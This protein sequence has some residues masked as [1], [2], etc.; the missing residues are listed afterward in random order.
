VQVEKIKDMLLSDMEVLKAPKGYLKAG[1]PYFDTLFGRDSL[2]AAWQML[3]ID[4]RIAKATLYWLAFYQAETINDK[5]DRE[6][7]RI[8]HVLRNNLSD[9][10]NREYA[11][12]G[13][14]DSTPLFIIVAGEYFKVTLDKDFLLQIWSNIVAAVNWMAVYGDADDDHLVEYERK[15][16]YGDFHQGWKD[17]VEDHLQI[18][19]PVAIVEVQGYAYAAYRAAADLAV[20]LGKDELF[21]NSWFEKAE[22]LRRTFHRSF[23]WE[24]ESYYYLALDGSKK[25]RESITSNP[26]HLLFTGIVPEEVLEKVIERIFQPDLFTPYG[27]RTVSENDPAFDPFSYH[28]GSV[29]PHD[30][31]IVYNG[32]KKLGFEK[33]ANRIKQALLLAYQELE[34]MPE[35]FR[36]EGGRI[37]PLTE[38]PEYVHHPG[39]NLG[40]ANRLQAW[41]ICALLDMLQED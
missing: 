16:Q 24:E 7:G 2:I 29:W 23:W 1:N 12:F 41:A 34:C 26:G 38:G 40:Y 25:P 9:M 6:P 22:G 30:N 3:R 36:V 39:P 18:S 15:N 10:P 17:C 37:F 33:E 19:L 32:L 27:I 11:Y 31:W 20:Q 4:S 35:L 14:A 8:L 5:A 13:S 28:L 21:A